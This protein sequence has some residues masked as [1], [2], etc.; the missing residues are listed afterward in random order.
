MGRGRSGSTI[1]ANVLGA[2]EGFFS[3]GEV[4]VLWD[5]IMLRSGRC[6]CGEPVAACPVWS[7]VAA[8]LQ[9]VDVAE[10][11]R[12][13][14]EVV[15]ERNLPRLLGARKRR[16]SWPALDR[17]TRLMEHVYAAISGVT[18]ASVIVDSSKRPSY[19]AF[20]AGLGNLAPVYLLLARDP[21]ASANSWKHRRHGSVHEGRE[22]TRRNVI[23]STVRW[24]LLNLGAESVLR[25]VGPGRGLTLRYEDFV[26]APR[27]AV[28]RTLDLV[29]EHPG[30]SPF[31]GE[32]IV[33]LPPNHTLAG[34]PARF[35]AGPIELEDTGAWRSQLNRADQWLAS[36][37]A[38]PF[39]R[40]YGYPL[41]PRRA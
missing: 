10:A 25:A 24:D 30:E 28:G 15:R 11:A 14:G 39:L 27:G 32:T 40:R 8:E 21:R 19:A 20:L 16:A 1:F 35:G 12:L 2:H 18:G 5:P 38:L 26:A 34:N 29:D 22:V 36:A 31:R 3:A 41:D 4:R 17:F 37:V 9:H 6:G 13:Q 23:D 33:E 7:A